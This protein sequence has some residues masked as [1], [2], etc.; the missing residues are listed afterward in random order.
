MAI[1]GTAP[2]EGMSQ[3]DGSCNILHEARGSSNYVFYT[4]FFIIYFAI[5]FR[6]LSHTIIAA[7]AVFAISFH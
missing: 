1:R 5:D 3:V 7:A 4:V 2:D 6:L